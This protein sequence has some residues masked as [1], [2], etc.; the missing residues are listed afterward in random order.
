MEVLPLRL[1]AL[2]EQEG[3]AINAHG[4]GAASA[5]AGAKH[6]G[7]HGQQQR[8]AHHRVHRIGLG[9]PETGDQGHGSQGQRKLH[10][11]SETHHRIHPQGQG[12]GGGGAAAG[13][14]QVLNARLQAQTRQHLDGIGEFEREL[15]HLRADRR[16]E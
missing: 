12:I 8:G 6:Q 2:R 1:S 14:D 4:E 9:D 5:I 11:D 15:A 3:L 10:P 13:M 7:H 16:I